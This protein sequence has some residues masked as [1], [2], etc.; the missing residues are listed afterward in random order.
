MTFP[1]GATA[2]VS[3]L[4]TAHME[5]ARGTDEQRR[6][7][8]KMIVQTIAS[9]FGPRWGTKATSRNAP[10]SKDSIAWD[11]MDGTFDSWDWQN[12]T[13]KAPQIYD[14]IP[15]TYP[16]IG[17]QFFINVE[18]FDHLAPAGPVD[19]PAP[20]KPPQR[21]EQLERLIDAVQQ[22]AGHLDVLNANVARL[23][24]LLEQIT[25]S[26]VQVHL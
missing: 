14:G 12:G 18:P 20:P 19:V 23:N 2:I 8:T 17:N 15:P 4:Y 24:L 5:L 11:N 6:A 1:P 3:A 9:R 25:R 7:L 21:D 13:T 22:S 16:R 10:Q 26:G